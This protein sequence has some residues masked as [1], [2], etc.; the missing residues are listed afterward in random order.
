MAELTKRESKE[1]VADLRSLY[2]Q[3]ETT[4]IPNI[5]PSSIIMKS[6]LNRLNITAE[7]D[8]QK[9]TGIEKANQELARQFDY[10]QVLESANQE[11]QRQLDTALL[12]ANDAKVAHKRALVNARE[13]NANLEKQ[14]E[15]SMTNLKRLEMEHT[16]GI[17]LLEGELELMRMDLASVTKYAKELELE[18]KELLKQ[19]M[20]ERQENKTLKQSDQD[21]FNELH[22]RIIELEKKNSFLSSQNKLKDEKH[23]KQQETERAFEEQKQT[24]EELRMALEN[25]QDQLAL[26]Q[27]EPIKHDRLILTPEGWEWT[28]FI[29]NAATKLLTADLTGLKN[30]L[31]YLKD[32][33]TEAFNRTKNQT[34]ETL[35]SLS[36]YIP[37]SSRFIKE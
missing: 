35:S 13:L 6:A 30:D 2:V 11:L 36:S 10:I 28:P 23:E 1:L 32:H 26:G 19:Q 4:A 37:F 16:N 8:K 25:T 3:N 33:R 5:T 9:L 12:N 18:K 31:V 21:L 17:H 24:I 14:L 20:I 34:L 22:D 15:N 27:E 7:K 29:S